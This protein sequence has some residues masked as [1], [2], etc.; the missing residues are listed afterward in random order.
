MEIKL[1][2]PTADELKFVLDSWSNSFKKSKYAGC[3]PNN[4]WASVSRTSITQLLSRQLCDVLVALSPTSDG[5]RGLVMGYIVGEPG[6]LHWVYTKKN[7]RRLGIGK[8]LLA[9]LTKNWDVQL[10]KFPRYTHKTDCA[11]R[12]LPP[13]WKHD[14]IPSR[15]RFNG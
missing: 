8:T 4:L 10:K 1:D 2:I 7:F 12:F 13:G 5:S 6:I 3:I 14:P 11:D 15:V 9:A